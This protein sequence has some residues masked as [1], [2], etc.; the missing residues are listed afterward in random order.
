MKELLQ[1][2]TLRLRALEPEDLELVFQMENDSSLWQYGC[3]NVPFSR[4]TI[5][6]YLE[7]NRND[8]YQDGQLRLVI[9]QEG[10]GVG[11][12]DLCNFDARN[13]RA[14]VSIALL[15][16][17][18]GQGIGVQTLTLLSEYVRQ[19]GIL[20]SLYAIVAKQNEAGM[21]LF[22]SAG[23]KEKGLLSDWLCSSE[24]TY[25]DAVLFQLVF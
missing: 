11:L 15:Q 21:R 6:Q 13:H 19:M 2:D 24:Q 3:N 9:E 16:D 7:E 25:I 4:F 12:V 22:A 5:R 23:Y 18:R 14:E 17:Y 8:I 1:H 10:Q 20:H